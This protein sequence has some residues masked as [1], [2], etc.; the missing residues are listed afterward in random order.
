MIITSSIEKFRCLSFGTTF[1]RDLGYVTVEAESVG[2]V[3]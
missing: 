1:L 3:K 2:G